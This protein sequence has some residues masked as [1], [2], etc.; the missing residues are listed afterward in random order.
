MGE[1]T[2]TDSNLAEYTS[3]SEWHIASQWNYDEPNAKIISVTFSSTD[4]GVM[5]CEFWSNIPRWKQLL[6]KVR[7]I[8]SSIARLRYSSNKTAKS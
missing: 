6:R 1:T 7:G 8:I 4:G 5:T 2:N 3:G